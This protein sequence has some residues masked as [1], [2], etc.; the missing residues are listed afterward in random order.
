MRLVKKD[1]LSP[2]HFCACVWGGYQSLCI[3][4]EETPW[5]NPLSDRKRYWITIIFALGFGVRYLACIWKN[6][7]SE[8][9]LKVFKDSGYVEQL[10]RMGWN[11]LNF[12]RCYLNSSTAGI[13]LKH[14]HMQF[15]SYFGCPVSAWH[16]SLL[17]LCQN[18]GEYQNELSGSSH[19]SPPQEMQ[20][21][22]WPT[23]ASGSLRGSKDILI[24]IVW[25]H[26]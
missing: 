24:C 3:T 23:R 17:L 22:P 5:D 12:K 9:E 14:I 20:P 2:D 11:H 8:A 19:D 18:C 10:L 16:A 7:P 21:T 26:F 13:L 15:F 1:L 6:S 4:H 25:L